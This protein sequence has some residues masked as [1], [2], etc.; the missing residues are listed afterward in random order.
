MV[1]LQFFVPEKKEEWNEGEKKGEI[2]S[3]GW[4]GGREEKKEEDYKALFFTYIK[5][6]CARLLKVDEN[7]DMQ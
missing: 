7:N 3:R 2:S 5:T 6:H 1:G 4:G